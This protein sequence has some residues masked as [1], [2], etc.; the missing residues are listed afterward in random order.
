M[1][2]KKNQISF[3]QF[4]ADRYLFKDKWNLASSLSRISKLEQTLRGRFIGSDVCVPHL[5]SE[6]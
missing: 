3:V 6:P 5:A 4:L 1:I 2:A